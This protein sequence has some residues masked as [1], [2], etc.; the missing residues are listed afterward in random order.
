M[1]YYDASNILAQSG[2]VLSSETDPL[3]THPF[4]LSSFIHSYD[5]EQ[6]VD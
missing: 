5:G 1:H 3:K 6:Y 2:E 4:L